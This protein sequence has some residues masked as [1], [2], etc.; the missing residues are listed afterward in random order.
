MWNTNFLTFSCFHGGNFWSSSSTSSVVSLCEHEKLYANYRLTSSRIPRWNAGLSETNSHG[1]YS[2]LLRS[3]KKK[4]RK[5]N[6]NKNNKNS[7]LATHTR[8]DFFNL[9]YHDPAVIYTK[10]LQV[11]HYGTVWLYYLEYF[12]KIYPYY[13]NRK[14][15]KTLDFQMAVARLK[16]DSKNSIFF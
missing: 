11:I 1:N 14:Y 7:S 16:L 15:T 13:V 8:D 6:L 4:N 9:F 10:I 12:L 5:R 2:K 3:K